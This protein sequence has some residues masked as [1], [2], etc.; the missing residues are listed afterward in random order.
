M[1]A[2]KSNRKDKENNFKENKGKNEGMT[3]EQWN[4]EKQEPQVS[5]GL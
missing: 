4:L 5:V 2:S 1:C 3:F